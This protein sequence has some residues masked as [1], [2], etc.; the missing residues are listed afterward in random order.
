MIT[1]RSSQE[2]NQFAKDI[3]EA[4]LLVLT[5]KLPQQ[6]DAL[7]LHGRSYGDDEGL[8]ELVSQLYKDGRIKSVIIPG[9]DGRRHGA[10]IPGEAWPG[11]KAWMKKL[12][13][14]GVDKVHLSDPGYNT[15]TE[16]D[17]FLKASS[18]KGWKSVA[19]LTQPHQILRA[20]L[21][22]VK[23]MEERN[24]WIRVYALIPPNTSWG[25]EVFGSQGEKSLPR[26]DHIK[27]ELVRIHRYQ[28]KGDLASFEQLFMYIAVRNATEETPADIKF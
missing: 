9:T 18:E 24:T 13:E 21:G 23:S 11:Q 2:E 12:K 7:F 17:S 14:L 25:S 16:T 20:M 3:Y 26:I 5:D 8:F 10:S 15:R 28:E 1:E 4:T 19:V 6:T 27:E 22:T